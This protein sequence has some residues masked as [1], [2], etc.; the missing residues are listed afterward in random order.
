MSYKDMLGNKL[1][2]SVELIMRRVTEETN[3]FSGQPDKKGKIINIVG[4]DPG[5]AEAVAR[6]AVDSSQAIAF[7]LR[8]AN[9]IAVAT[10]ITPDGVYTLAP[11]LVSAA[12]VLLAERLGLEEVNE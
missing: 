1:F 6:A 3:W 5:D 9:L 12:S 8:T 11:D 10:A 2:G 4:G 7:E